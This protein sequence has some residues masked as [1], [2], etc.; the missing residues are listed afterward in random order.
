MFNPPWGT[1]RVDWLISP[2]V[3]CGLLLVKPYRLWIRMSAFLGI[4]LPSPAYSVRILSIA[5]QKNRYYSSLK[6]VGALL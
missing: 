6:S 4:K 1:G 3:R 2:G 5:T